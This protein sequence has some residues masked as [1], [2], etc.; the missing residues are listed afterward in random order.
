MRSI[1][2]NTRRAD[3]I[4]YSHGKID[5][6]A[7]IVSRLRLTPG[8][9]IDILTDEE[10]YYL[11]VRQRAPVNGRHEGMVYPSKARGN[12]YRTF[13]VRLSRAI[14]QQYGGVRTMVRLTAGELVYDERYGELLTL[15]TKHPI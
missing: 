10:E 7:N 1:L 11:Y 15:I 12:H 9:V 3:I 8:D 4:F 6:C 5:I 13:S 2:D 14:L